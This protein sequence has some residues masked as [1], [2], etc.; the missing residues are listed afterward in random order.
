MK[1]HPWCSFFFKLFTFWLWWKFLSHSIWCKYASKVIC[2][3]FK[4]LYTIF[5][6]LMRNLFWDD[7]IWTINIYTATKQIIIIFDKYTG[8]LN[9]LFCGFCSV[10]IIFQYIIYTNFWKAHS[11]CLDLMV[12]ILFRWVLSAV[13]LNFIW[14]FQNFYIH[15][16]NGCYAVLLFIVLVFFLIYGVQVFFKVR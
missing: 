9:I 12:Y 16:F 15:V 11:L 14:S 13:T 10:Y 5:S 1:V 7:F 2:S 3:Q 6:F 4:N 8:V